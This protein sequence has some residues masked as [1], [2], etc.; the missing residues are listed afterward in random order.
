M[1]VELIALDTTCTEIKWIKNLISELSLISKLVSAIS[2]H[3]DNKAII[4]LTNQKSTNEK[5]NWYI[6][7]HHK[8]V[9]NSKRVISFP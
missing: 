4:K 6:Q 2:I 8:F 3:C 5:M 7:I 1:E 9:R